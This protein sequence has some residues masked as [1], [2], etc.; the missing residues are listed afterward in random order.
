MLKSNLILLIRLARSLKDLIGLLIITPIRNDNQNI[1]WVSKSAKKLEKD[2]KNLLTNSLTEEG[3]PT[4]F[5]A[6]FQK[7]GEMIIIVNPII[8]PLKTA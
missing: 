7:P 6:R 5:S 4:E 1:G 2:L 8:V 3:S